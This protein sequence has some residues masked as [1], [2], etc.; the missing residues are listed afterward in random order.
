MEARQSKLYWPGDPRDPRSGNQR[1]STT[2]GVSTQI[3]SGGC[4]RVDTREGSATPLSRNVA[5][6]S[7]TVMLNPSRARTTEIKG[8]KPNVLRSTLEELPMIS[9]TTKESAVY[10]GIDYHKRTIAVA[11]GDK[12][13]R[14]LERFNLLNQTELVTKFFQQ[15]S[16]I[17]CVVESCRGYEWFVEMLQK[18]GHTVHVG[19]SRSIKLIA[20]SRCKTDKVDSQILMEL[21]AIKYLPTT[22]IPTAKERE[23]RE[24]LRHRSS[25]VQTATRSKLRVHALLDKENKGIRFPFSKNGRKQLEELDL[26]ESRRRIIQHELDVIDFAEEHAHE[27]QLRIHLLASYEPE[28]KRLRS[29]PGFEVLM[30]AAFLAEVGDVS[31]FKNGDQVAAYFGLVPRVYASG[32]TMRCGRI[33]KAGSKFMRWML[34]Q[35]AW[36]AIK[37]SPN[38]RQSFGAIGRRRGQK[39]AIVAIARKLATIAFRVLRDKTTYKEELLDAGLARA[40]F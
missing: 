35:A 17:E 6:V 25:L 8:S 10:A 9:N 7:E 18:Q 2:L 19:D 15:F 39:V 29:I 36:A 24:L 40:S 22:Y 3:P 4:A 5:A 21:L 33:T 14:V 20:H 16:K 11:V 34:V 28:I 37:A 30:A 32:N 23:Y 13:G 31:R 38:L 1:D 12:E 27:Q 26:S